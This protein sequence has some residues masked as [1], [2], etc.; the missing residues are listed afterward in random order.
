MHEL[1]FAQQIL[2]CV[3]REARKHGAQQVTCIRL[4]VG[5][6][7]GVDK[8]NLSFC[9][10][11]IAAGTIMD[12][13]AVEAT[14]VASQLVCPTCGRFPLDGVTDSACPRCGRNAEVEPATE[15][16]IEEI[17]LDVEEDQTGK[18]D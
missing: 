5:K 17:E 1:S 16:L 18:E 7:S 10:E 15:V 13:A 9:L 3:E 12:G 14:E 11:A 8:G 6:L 2:H 4:K